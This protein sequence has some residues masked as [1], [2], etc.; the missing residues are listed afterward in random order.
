MRTLSLLVALAL[1]GVLSACDGGDGGGAS[2]E[3]ADSNARVSQAVAVGLSGGRASFREAR[4]LPTYPCTGGGS[5]DVTQSGTTYRMAF[6]DCY[7]VS[8]AFDVVSSVSTSPSGLSVQSRFDG[9]LA[10]SGGCDI[11]YDAFRASTETDLSGSSTTLTYDGAI[12]A[13]C[14]SGT[15]ACQFDGA[16][17]EIGADGSGAPTSLD[18]YCQ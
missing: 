17:F 18:G 5:V 10:V 9:D 11:T 7:D 12:T 3:L 2:G 15:A 14:P 8:G 13:S 16:R 4:L 6:D 1:V